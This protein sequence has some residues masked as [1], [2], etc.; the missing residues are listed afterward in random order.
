M[1]AFDVCVKFRSRFKAPDWDGEDLTG[2]T[3][4][5]YCEQGVGDAIMFSRFLPLLKEKNPAKIIVEI[6]ESLLPLF[7]HNFDF[8]EF[9]GRGHGPDYLPVPE[10]D[11]VASI[12]SLGYFF[13]IRPESISGKPYLRMPSAAPTADG[14]KRIGFCWMGNPV[15][16]QDMYRSLP[17]RHFKRLSDLKDVE[18][19]SL[20]KDDGQFRRWLGQL[21]NLR[22]GAAGLRFTNLAPQLE[23]FMDTAECIMQLDLV[24]TVDT[25]IAH[26]A[27]S[28][29]KPT[30]V[31]VPKMSDWRWMRDRTDSLWY[32]TARLFRQQT[33]GDWDSV[34]DEVI[35][36]LEA[37][38]S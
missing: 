31:L 6:Q 7:R 27:A 10:S 33:I 35:A 21:V 22:E 24:V 12:C 9:R 29:G 36:E 23:T 19:Y 32:D 8:V 14:V 1:E 18:L 5:L 3:I 37:T 11:V 38:T 4:C 34:F 25:S 17:M 13:N 26:L 30:W 20:Q 15:H 28:L 2:K 16:G